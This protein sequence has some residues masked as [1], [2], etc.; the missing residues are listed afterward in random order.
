MV[1]VDLKGS[2]GL[3]AVLWATFRFVDGHILLDPQIVPYGHVHHVRQLER[4]ITNVT[5]ALETDVAFAGFSMFPN[6]TLSSMDLTSAC[7]SALYQTVYCDDATS[8]LM[9]SS[10]IGSFDNSTLTALVCDTGCESSIAQLHDSVLASCGEA[11]DLVPGLPFLGLVDMLWSNWNQSCFVDPTTGD[12]CNDLCSYCNVEKLALMQ[13]NAFTPVYDDNWESTYEYVAGACN[14]SVVDFNAT[15]SAFNVT[16][17]SSTS[18]CVSGNMYTTKQGDTC[19]SIAQSKSVSAAT[20]FYINSNILN[21]S[22]ILAGTSLCLPLACDS[23]YT[24]QANDTCTS[25]A[26]DAGIMTQNLLSYNSQLN[27]NCTNLQS[28]NP[29]W[30][31]TLCVST[32]GGTYT[33]QA[34]NTSTSTGSLIVDPPTGLTVAKGTTTDCGEWYANDGKLNLTCTQI[35]IAYEIAINL[36]TEANPSLDKTTCDAD[37]VLGDAYCIDPLTGWNWGNAST[38]TNSSA[39]SSTS[40]N[41]QT[42]STVAATTASSSLSQTT[43]STTSTSSVIPPGPTQSGITSACDEYYVTVSG[44]SCASIE[45]AYSITFAEFYAWNPAIGSDCTDLWLDEAYC[46]GVSGS[47]SATTTSSLTPPAPTQSGITSACTE[48]YVT[49]TGDSCAA[50][51]AAYSITFAEFYAWNPAVGSDCTALWVDEAYCVSVS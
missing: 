30:G 18:N 44:D 47:A 42:T 41:S 19:D 25:I 48:Y 6:G 20:M 16:V 34:L 7:E 13:A 15:A 5:H 45:A 8:S 46:V 37:L 1:A 4:S 32:P 10:Y 28:I 38:S 23:L 3:L 21:C 50:I 11:T 49:V 17:P 35:C 40:P 31:S 14:I 9:T 43:I 39:A 2:P 36:F 12:N 29:Y 26:V 33:G 24:V 27:W 22:S 51:E